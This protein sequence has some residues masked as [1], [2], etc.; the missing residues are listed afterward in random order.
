MDVLTWLRSNWE[1]LAGLAC[2][3]GGAV[4]TGLAYLGVRSSRYLTEDLS[5]IMSGGIG[6]LFLVGVGAL[7]LITGRLHV[8]RQE[9]LR[10]A[11]TARAAETGG[12]VLPPGEHP[13]AEATL[14]ASKE[15]V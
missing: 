8:L 6:G 12:V 11:E 4:A 5:Y 1:R 10:A 14:V 2:L 15:R 7:L 9:L 3:V 13:L